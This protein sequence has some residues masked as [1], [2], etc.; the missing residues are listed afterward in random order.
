MGPPAAGLPLNPSLEVNFHI[1]NL[2]ITFLLWACSP[3]TSSPTSPQQRVFPGRPR[4]SHWQLAQD[5][6]VS[7]DWRSLEGREEVCEVCFPPLRPLFWPFKCLYSLAPASQIFGPSCRLLL[8]VGERSWLIGL[9]V[10]TLSPGYLPSHV[11]M[12][13]WETLAVRNPRLHELGVTRELPFPL[14]FLLAPRGAGSEEPTPLSYG[15]PHPE[16]PFPFCSLRDGGEEQSRL[17]GTGSERVGVGEFGDLSCNRLVLLAPQTCTSGASA[18][19]S[20]AFRL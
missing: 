7:R 9:S 6:A 5:S 4:A 10:P 15:T 3:Q 16:V 17:G 8:G 11:A 13:G 18:A 2:G 19:P 20:G 12:A 1:S 14:A